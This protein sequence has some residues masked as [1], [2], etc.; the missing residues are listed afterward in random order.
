MTVDETLRS[1]ADYLDALASAIRTINGRLDNLT[2]VDLEARL[3]F[4]GALNDSLGGVPRAIFGESQAAASLGNVRPWVGQA[5]VLVD[6]TFETLSAVQPNST[7]SGAASGRWLISHVLNSG[8]LPMSHYLGWVWRRGTPNANPFN[9]DVSEVHVS[10]FGANAANL[11][12]YLYPGVDFAPTGPALPFL[13]A[14]MRLYLLLAVDATVGTAEVTLEIYNVTGGTV[15]ASSQ[16]VDLKAL[17]VLE[18]VQLTAAWQDTPAN[19]Q[20]K[21]WRW[22]LKTHIVKPASSTGTVA[23][24]IAEPQLHF[25]YTPDAMPFVPAI[26]NW[27]PTVRPAD[28]QSLVATDTIVP[29]QLG[30]GPLKGIFAL[31]GAITMTSTPTLTDGLDGQW[32]ILYNSVF[33]AITIQDQGTLAGSNLRLTAATLVLGARDSIQLMFSANTG[34]WVQIGNLVS[35]L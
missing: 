21:S 24:L 22:R 19:F 6:P 18:S 35:V 29:P 33:N 20:S 32:V 5:N 26:A 17:A 9:S 13:V 7:T 2:R 1:Q 31:S 28:E 3:G 34:D 27:Y 25:A 10:G 14:S 15:V 8:V 30:D 4:G 11:D 23:P 12:V 16:V